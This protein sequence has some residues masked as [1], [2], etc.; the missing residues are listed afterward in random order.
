[1]QMTEMWNIL[2]EHTLTRLCKASEVPAGGVKQVCLLAEGIEIAVYNLNGEYFATD[3]VCTHGMVSL[4][5]GEV[6]EGQIVCPL[7]GGAFDIRT[8]KATEAPCRLALKTYKVV[9]VGDE[10]HADLG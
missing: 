6:D 1:M 9:L 8:G 10:I 4:S 7:H 5:E 2:M 3:D